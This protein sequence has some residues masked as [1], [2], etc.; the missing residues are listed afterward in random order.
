MKDRDMALT[1]PDGTLTDAPIWDE[2]LGSDDAPTWDPSA[3]DPA[4]LSKIEKLKSLLRSKGF[5]D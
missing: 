3:G 4:P 2:I 1:H 5:V